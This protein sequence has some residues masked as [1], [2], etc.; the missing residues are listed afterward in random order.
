M[1][2]GL[3]QFLNTISSSGDVPIVDT[4]N[5]VLWGKLGLTLISSVIATLFLGWQRVVQAGS[6]AVTDVITGVTAFFTGS[7]PIALSPNMTELELAQAQGFILFLAYEADQFIT[8][9]WNGSLAQVPG[10]LQ[11]PAAILVLLVTWW[12]VSQGLE[13]AREEVL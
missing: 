7:G 11:M 12:I 9:L 8:V 13:F 2:D 1:H 3:E 10:F 4:S 6:N 5:P